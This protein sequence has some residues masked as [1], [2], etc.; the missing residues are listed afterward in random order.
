MSRLV[1]HRNSRKPPKRSRTIPIY[2]SSDRGHGL[3]DG[4][5]FKCWHCG[6]HNNTR[7]Q[8]LGGPDSPSGAAFTDYADNPDY[9][10][11]YGIAI[12][13]GVTHS[14][15]AQQN[16][17]DGNPKAVTNAI[18]SSDGGTGCSFCGTLNYRGDY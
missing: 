13:G 18:K 16:G 10:Q 6:Q 5:L 2:G 11:T 14:F 9:A 8:K 15:V 7:K 17:I 12:L 1:K 4:V 3:D